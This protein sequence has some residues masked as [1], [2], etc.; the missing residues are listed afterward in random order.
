M[1]LMIR[2]VATEFT[3]LQALVRTLF[4]GYKGE[5]DAIFFCVNILL[6]LSV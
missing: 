2:S 5:Y 3:E 6:F 4:K 1:S